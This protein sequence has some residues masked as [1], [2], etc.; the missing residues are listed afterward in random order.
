MKEKE[1]EKERVRRGDGGILKYEERRKKRK[2]EAERVQ[3]V[4]H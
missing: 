3:E 2:V 1:N 4:W